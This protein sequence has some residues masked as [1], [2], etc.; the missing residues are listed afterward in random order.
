VGRLVVPIVPDEGRT[1]GMEGL[2]A[3]YG[4]YASLGQLY[5]P[6]DAGQLQ[7]YKEATNGQVLQEGINEAGAMASFIAAGT[8]Y[9]VHQVNTIPFYIYY[10]MFGFQ[11]IGDLIWAAGDMRC[12]GFLMGGTAGR[13]TLNGE[14]LQHEDGHSHM[15]AMNVP[16]CRAY[17]PAFGY[18]L[19]V[20]IQDGIRRMYEEQQDCFYYL[21]I[22]NEN[23]DHLAMP[24]G[25]EE[26]I[27]RGIYRVRPGAGR[28]KL[29]AHLWG[30]GSI[31]NCALRAQEILAERYGVSAD[32]WSVTSYKC[33][34]QDAIEASRWNML[35]PEEKPRKP[36]V[37]GLFEGAKGP[38]VAASDYVRALPDMVAPFVPG[39]VTS[40]GTDGF[41]RSET[42]EGLRRF[43]EVDAESITVATLH[44]LCRRGEIEASTVAKAIKDLGLEP[45]KPFPLLI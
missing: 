15:M 14:G 35:H 1:F 45:G 42:R 43:F 5:T 38:V 27:I 29:Q 6:V 32:V 12:R 9:S 8:A 31:L 17:D 16:N 4:I 26:G 23:Y 37:T 7:F 41:G 25:A 33:L 40:L 19:A 13:T 11:R 2:Y 3:R 22:A 21:T 18:E 36:W 24:E 10:S 28:K 34:R 39:G 44:A 20:I 30:S